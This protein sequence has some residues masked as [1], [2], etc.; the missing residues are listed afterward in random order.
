MHAP[1]RPRRRAGAATAMPPHAAHSP[2]A[3]HAARSP[4][5]CA[6]PHAAYCLPPAPMPLLQLRPLTHDLMK[7]TLEALGFRVTKVGH[8]GRAAWV[9]RMCY[10]TQQLGCRR[11]VCAHVLLCHSAALQGRRCYPATADSL[12]PHSVSLVAHLYD[13]W[14]PTVLLPPHVRITLY[15]CSAGADQL[16]PAA[17]APPAGAHH[18]AGWQH[19][20]CPRALRAR[21]RH[22]RRPAS[23][24]G[25]GGGGCGCAAL[26]CV[27][28]LLALPAWCGCY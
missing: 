25:A 3:P 21:A 6:A 4:H 18:C 28:P 26:G 5:P 17:P 7:S 11:M 20:P 12:L 1:A 23:R 10:A 2:C 16:L 9:A 15:A 24:R 8:F 13:R 22:A 14:L 19:V 27:L